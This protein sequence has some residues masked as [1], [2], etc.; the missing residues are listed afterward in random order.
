MSKELTNNEKIDK[1]ADLLRFKNEDE[2]IEFELGVLQ[3]KKDFR[4]NYESFRRA[5]KFQGVESFKKELIKEFGKLLRI[6]VDGKT[7][8]IN[9]DEAIDLI[10]KTN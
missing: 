5:H 8:F 2:M 9:Y 7:E 6:Y 1:L 4:E 3:D 10:N